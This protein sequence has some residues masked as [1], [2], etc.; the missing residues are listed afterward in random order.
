M[1][2][3]D[4]TLVAKIELPQRDQILFHFGAFVF[5]SKIMAWEIGYD[6]NFSSKKKFGAA[7]IVHLYK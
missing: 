5:K 7:H 4:C 2:S 1:R 3:L 6:N